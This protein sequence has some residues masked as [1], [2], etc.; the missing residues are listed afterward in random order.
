MQ[1]FIVRKARKNKMS[2][3]VVVDVKR[4]ELVKHFNPELKKNVSHFW[5][6]NEAADFAEYLSKVLSD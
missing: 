3:F 4:K 5:A 2:C 1:N 6:K